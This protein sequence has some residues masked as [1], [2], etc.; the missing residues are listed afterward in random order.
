MPCMMS[1]TVCP[2]GTTLLQGMAPHPGVH[3]QPKLDSMVY[4]TIEKQA[5]KLGGGGDGSNLGGIR[6]SMIKNIVC[7]CEILKELITYHAKEKTMA[8]AVSSS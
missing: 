3:R 7:L 6:K 1:S 8:Q 2:G 4:K 5:L